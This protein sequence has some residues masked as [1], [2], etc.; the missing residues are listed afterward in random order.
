MPRSV[1]YF[2]VD[3]DLHFRSAGETLVSPEQD[4]KSSHRK[5]IHGQLEQG[6]GE[7]DDIIGVAGGRMVEGAGWRAHNT[8][9]LE[10]CEYCS[11][12]PEGKERV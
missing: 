5:R 4:E 1:F 8:G 7:Q 10:L 12:F 6:R 9:L 3:E 11:I 2:V